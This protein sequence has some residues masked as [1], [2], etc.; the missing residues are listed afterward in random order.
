MK[1]QFLG[2]FLLCQTIL[3]AQMLESIKIQGT[4]KQMQAIAQIIAD[5][6]NEKSPSIIKRLRESDSMA[7]TKNYAFLKSKMNV[8][9]SSKFIEKELNH[10]G[11]GQLNPDYQ[12]LFFGM[13]LTT[14]IKEGTIDEII[15][16]FD[17]YAVLSDVYVL[18]SD[19]QK[20]GLK[21]VQLQL[22][23]LKRTE[24]EELGLLLPLRSK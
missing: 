8:G 10:N 11:I 13:V 12:I 2:L 15:M 23:K 19:H 16:F 9:F 4:Q 17:Q 3:H 24:F 1:N 22:V 20:L 14:L 21:E 5:R 6:V 7:F 18:T